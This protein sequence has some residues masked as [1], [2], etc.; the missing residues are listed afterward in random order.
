MDVWGEEDERGIS[1]RNDN[2]NE[3]DVSTLRVCIKSQMAFILMD[4]ES[5]LK[6]TFLKK[7]IDKNRH[8]VLSFKVY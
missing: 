2:R 8:L 5:M 7:D 4:N 3:Y 6:Q 1:G